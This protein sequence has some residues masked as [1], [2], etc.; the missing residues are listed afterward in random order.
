MLD[1]DLAEIYGVT[2]K[3]L[4]EQARRNKG[5]FPDDFMFALTRE[6]FTNLKSQS[7]TSRWGGRRHPPNVF[8]EHGAVMLASVLKSPVAVM[9]SI[10][11]VRAFVR[12]REMLASHEDLARKL[13]DLEKKYDYRFQVVFDAIRQLMEPPRK[14]HPKIGFK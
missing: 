3:R 4:N 8:T 14:P 1:E 11:V 12:L 2:T 6:E 9:A 7:A 13:T 10:Q 5:R